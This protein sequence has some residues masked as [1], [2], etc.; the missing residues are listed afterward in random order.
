MEK[1]NLR[2]LLIGA[3]AVVGICCAGQPAECLFGGGT[4]TNYCCEKDGSSAKTLVHTGKYNA[5]K[6][7]YKDLQSK[8]CGMTGKCV[9]HT[10]AKGKPP[11]PQGDQ[12]VNNK[13][14]SALPKTVTL[15]A[16]CKDFNG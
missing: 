9:V 15:D 12:N 7:T 1:K 11:C 16:L 8:V 5:N 14:N 6:M 13:V 4:T 10:P 2:N 3:S